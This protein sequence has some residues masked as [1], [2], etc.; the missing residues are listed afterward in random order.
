MFRIVDVQN[1]FRK[2]RS[3]TDQISSISSIIENIKKT[4]MSTFCAFID[5]RKA[6]DYMNRNKLWQR[7]QEIMYLLK[8]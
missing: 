8:C 4:K 5:F 6:S 3:N 7:L 1:G 2:K